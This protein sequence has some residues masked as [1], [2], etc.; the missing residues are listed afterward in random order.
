MAV[1]LCLARPLSRPL[2]ARGGAGGSRCGSA[3]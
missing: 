3:Q 1:P 2:I